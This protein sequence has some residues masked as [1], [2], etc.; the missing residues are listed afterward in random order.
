MKQAPLNMTFE[1]DQKVKYHTIVGTIAF[2]SDHYLS[3]LVSKGEHRSQD[4]K[5][6]VYKSQQ[7]EIEI[8]E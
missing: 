6:I 4:V 7:N 3:I 8:L 5:V 2:I 1:I